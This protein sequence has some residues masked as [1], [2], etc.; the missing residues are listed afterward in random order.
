M[1]LKRRMAGQPG[2]SWSQLIISLTSAF[3]TKRCSVVIKKVNSP[4]L[5]QNTMRLRLVQTLD[6]LSRSGKLNNIT[7]T[8]SWNKRVISRYVS[9]A[10]VILVPSPLI[11]AFQT[12]TFPHTPR[13]C[14]FW[15]PVHLS[16]FLH[17]PKTKPFPLSRKYYFY[18]VAFN[19][20]MQTVGAHL[21]VLSFCKQFSCSVLRP[22][23]TISRCC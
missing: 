7:V 23:Y 19:S 22:I 1:P 9:S 17:P 13:S 8:R 16:E 11:A 21:T 15:T 3:R 5:E 12:A 18:G 6:K 20:S 4:K 10:P 2:A 14:G